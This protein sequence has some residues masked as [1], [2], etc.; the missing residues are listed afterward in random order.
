MT[1]QRLLLVASL[2]AVA[3]GFHRT[4]RAATTTYTGAW[5]GGT[6]A[7][8]D[9]VVL[10]AGASVGGPVQADGVLQF[11]QTTAL[12]MSQSLTGTGRLALTNTGTFI[13]TGLA[14]GTA[15]FDMTAAAA[16][17]GLDIG[18]TGTNALIVGATG[19]GTL[20]V[21]GGT[22]RNGLGFLGFGAGSFG[23]AT[24]TGGTWASAA[25]AAGRILYLGYSGTGVL[26]VSGGLVTNAN[27]YLGFASGAV[28]TATVSGGSWTN[29]GTLYVGGAVGGSGG[30]G[31]LTIAGGNVS[32][33]TAYVG[34][35]ATAAGSVIVKGGTWTT[36]ANVNVG[37]SGTGT[38]AISGSGGSGGVVVV[39]GTLAKGSGGTIT[40]AAGGTLHIGSGT[41]SGGLATDLV[42]SGAIV[43]NRTGSGTV[44]ASISGTGS[45]AVAG[46]ATLRFTG[47]SSYTGPT[48]LDARVHRHGRH[49]QAAVHEEGAGVEGRGAGGR[50][51]RQHP[52]SRGRHRRA[53]HRRR[54]V[55][56]RVGLF[57]R[58]QL[59]RP[60]RGRP[61][62]RRRKPLPLGHRRALAHRPRGESA[63]I[64][65]R[66]DRVADQ[67]HGKLERRAPEPGR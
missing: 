62:A 18:A 7:A 4:A 26:D 41:T 6:I 54:D 32:S 65:R 43:F 34:S 59:V 33:V 17:G 8:G 57:R 15:R 30:T 60:G 35:N 49:P 52:H 50:G 51:L 19:T 22:V 14:S 28:G 37:T 25:G 23:A 1:R 63:G 46:A 42:N 47:T 56:E 53:H 58:A 67:L 55:L 24:V 38:L 21:T 64:R 20:S 9:T 5:A 48:T 61:A 66:H 3:M 36:S 11:N 27:G 31:T 40:L 2:L 16:N 39:G 45:L 29:R 44:A 10:D 13:L 12:T